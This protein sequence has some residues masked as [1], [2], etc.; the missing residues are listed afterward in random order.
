MKRTNEMEVEIVLLQFLNTIATTTLDTVEKNA[1]M[2][3]N[4]RKAFALGAMC[5]M[6]GIDKVLKPKLLAMLVKENPKH[7]ENLN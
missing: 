1:D 5:V 3:M 2:P 4:E 6:E 7:F